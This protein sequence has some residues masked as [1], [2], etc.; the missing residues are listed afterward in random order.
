MS[1][2][3][4]VPR[5]LLFGGS[6]NP[7]HHGHLIVARDVAER[8]DVERVILIPSAVPPH[9]QGVPLAP[10]ESRLEMCRAA[11]RDEPRFEV[12]DWE[13]H[14]TPPNYSLLTVRHF[15]EQLGAGAW[16]GWL[17]GMDSLIELPTWHRVGDLAAECT[18]V[19]AVRPGFA[20]PDLHEHARCIAADDLRRIERHV[21]VTPHIEI[22]ASAIRRRVA[23]GRSIRYLTPD[24]VIELI[25][26]HGLYA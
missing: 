9:K 19:T 2:T 26:R 12:S 5:T 18:I 22:S 20:L 6:F 8:L 3:S 14:Q 23:A 24:A 15:R 11:V 13:A 21:L 25:A 10:I 1:Q 7:I 17:I 16:I 4:G